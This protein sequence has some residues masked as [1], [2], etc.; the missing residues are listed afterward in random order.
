MP[1]SKKLNDQE[2]STQ[3]TAVR[4]PLISQ[5]GSGRIG[6]TT[7]SPGLTL[8]WMKAAKS[9]QR[10]ISQRRPTIQRPNC[11]ENIVLI[12]DY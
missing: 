2:K 9:H 5:I 6:L 8:R 12:G 10:V 3:K 11:K 1:P 4:H 7:A